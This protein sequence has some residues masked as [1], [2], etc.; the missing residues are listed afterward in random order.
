MKCR[1]LQDAGVRRFV[2]VRGLGIPNKRN[3]PNWWIWYAVQAPTPACRILRNPD[4]IAGLFQHLFQKKINIMISDIKILPRHI[5]IRIPYLLKH[6]RI[7]PGIGI[8]VV[9]ANLFTS[10]P[11]RIGN[12]HSSVR[13][14]HIFCINRIRVGV[15]FL[16]RCNP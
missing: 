12:K 3:L 14:F 5:P 16:G 2:L 13:L 1:T 7:L 15:L 4:R 6:L 11:R 10:L 8:S 9:G